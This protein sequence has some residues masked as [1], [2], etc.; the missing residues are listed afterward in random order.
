MVRTTLPIFSR[1]AR[2]LEEKTMK[3]NLRPATPDDLDELEIRYEQVMKPYVELTHRWDP[4]HFR[5]NFDSSHSQII[6]INGQNAGL[7][8]FKETRFLIQLL[9]IQLWPEFQKLGI[10]TAILTGLT[11]R[12]DRLGLPITL[13]VLNGNPAKSLYERLGFQKTEDLENAVAMKRNP[14]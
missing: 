5:K 10:G 13:R 12:A 9:D 1:D 3:Y 4:D 7:L 8:T 11:D 6:T 14:Q 2:F